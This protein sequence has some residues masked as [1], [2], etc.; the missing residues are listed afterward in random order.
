MQPAARPHPQRK[1]VYSEYNEI[2]QSFVSNN[3]LN[4]E[5]VFYARIFQENDCRN[6]MRYYIWE[7]ELRRVQ[8]RVS[9][10][11]MCVRMQQERV[12]WCCAVEKSMIYSLSGKKTQKTLDFHRIGRNIAQNAAFDHFRRKL[13]VC[14]QNVQN[15]FHENSCSNS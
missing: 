12:S 6:S 9:D 1:T 2:S 15:I 5:P 3:R 13:P 4:R 14:G 7:E 11:H 10:P 8:D